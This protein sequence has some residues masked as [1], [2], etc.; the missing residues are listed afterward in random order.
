MFQ[1]FVK[2]SVEAAKF[3]Q[4]AFDAKLECEYFDEDKKFYMH[5]ELNVYGQILAISELTEQPPTT[6]NTMMFCLHFGKGNADKVYKTYEVLKEGAQPHE[7]V[8]DVGYSEHEFAL[9]DKYG[10]WWCVFE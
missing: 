7:P 3:Y 6:G 4:K 8:K 9:I 10:V 1:I 5:S 2:G